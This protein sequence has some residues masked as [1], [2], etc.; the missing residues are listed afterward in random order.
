MN[1]P[2]PEIGDGKYSLR[3]E[4]ALISAEYL[5]WDTEVLGVRSARINTLWCMNVS[6]ISELEDLLNKVISKMENDG[7]KFVD[8]RVGL[9]SF[10][11]IQ[12]SERAGFI[13]T[14]VMNIYLSKTPPAEVNPHPDYHLVTTKPE[15]Q[16]DI[17]T[18]LSI[19]KNLFRFSR[20]YQDLHISK[21]VAD[22]FY[23]KLVR[24]FMTKENTLFTIAYKGDTPAAFYIGM[25]DMSLPID[26]TL[27][28]LW[29]IGV[30]P[31]HAGK[32]LGKYMLNH[33]LI[34][35]HKTCDLVEIGTQ[36]NNLPANTI[37]NRAQLP[38]VANIASFHR[39]TK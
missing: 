19:S 2:I 9:H 35:L 12:M 13:L 34:N 38:I 21:A 28:Y 20:M 23:S 7:I 1:L 33:F 37:Y 18:V 17:E 15:K 36:I 8:L 14:D 3:S 39:W 6:H 16:T 5:E 10:P 32:G 27:G 31:E 26:N 22:D 4:N 29:L 30:A 24:Y 25:Q 11:M